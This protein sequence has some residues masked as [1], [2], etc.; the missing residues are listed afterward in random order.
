MSL[1][2]PRRGQ[3]I[4]LFKIF[5]WTPLSD[6]LKVANN[7]FTENPHQICS[8]QSSVIWS[9]AFLLCP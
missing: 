9:C 4:G 1:Y 2:G 5:F 6:K 7:I 8:D 3:A